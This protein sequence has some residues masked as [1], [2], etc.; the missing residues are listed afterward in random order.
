MANRADD[1][2]V[3]LIIDTLSTIDTAQFITP[4]NVLTDRVA[5]KDT[6]GI[7]SSAALTQIETWLA[8]HFYATR[9]QQYS[10]KKT[11]DASAKFQIGIPREG[12]LLDGTEWGRNAMALDFTGCLRSINK[13]GKVS[14]DWLGKAPS[15]QIDY[16]NR[17]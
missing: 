14:M 8:A 3:R 12:G 17:N 7:L 13:G 9:D 2:G 1:A 10:E 4:A 15:N 5:T 6:A 16:V 11:G